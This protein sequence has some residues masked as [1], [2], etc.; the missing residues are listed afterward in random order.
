MVKIFSPPAIDTNQQFL[1]SYCNHTEQTVI[2]RITNLEERD[3]EQVV[4]P[5]ETFEFTAPSDAVLEISRQ[6][7]LGVIQ[8]TIPCSELQISQS[9]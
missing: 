7:V 3:C 6:T 8:E 2:V 4:F 9:H 5:Q 1:C